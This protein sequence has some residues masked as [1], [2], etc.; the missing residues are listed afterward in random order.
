MV[1]PKEDV[2]ANSNGQFF[3]G[4]GMRYVTKVGGIFL[5]LLA[6]LGTMSEIA[7]AAEHDEPI[8]VLGKVNVVD[9]GATTCI[10]CKM[11]EPILDQ[12]KQEYRGRVEVIFIDV[13]VQGELARS[14]SIRLIPTQ[15]FFDKNGIE[16]GRHEGFMDREQIVRALQQ[17]GVD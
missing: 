4:E 17:L 10:P 11:M 3:H 15:V 2:Q 12:L 1:P 5:L 7:W 8:P 13:S 14:Y 9:F 16:V 6:F